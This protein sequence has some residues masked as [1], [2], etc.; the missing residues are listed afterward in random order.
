MCL[1]LSGNKHRRMGSIIHHTNHRGMP[2]RVTGENT[3]SRRATTSSLH[4]AGSVYLREQQETYVF[5]F[6]HGASCS[7]TLAYV[8]MSLHNLITATF[9]L[10]FTERQRRVAGGL[11]TQ[12]G[13]RLSTEREMMTRTSIGA[14][15]LRALSRTQAYLIPALRSQASMP[16]RPAPPSAAAIKDKRRGPA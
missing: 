16:S 2:T 12:L 7:P 13:S 14:K 10:T 8:S 5:S 4:F 9:R 1:L 6:Q 11:R 3:L 15:S